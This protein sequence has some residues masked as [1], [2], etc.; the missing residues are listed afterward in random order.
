MPKG[1][2]SGVKRH[3]PTGPLGRGGTPLLGRT[4]ERRVGENAA[5][6]VLVVAH[7]WCW[8]E[9]VLRV[10]EHRDAAPVA[11]TGADVL[12]RIAADRV[13]VAVVDLDDA[14]GAATLAE[15]RERDLPCVAVSCGRGRNE[16]AAALNASASYA[17]K[18]VNYSWPD[19]LNLIP[20]DQSCQES[21]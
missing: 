10:L 17:V 21:N 5:L 16:V 4:V 2:P 1:P 11:A 13:D 12:R 14:D 20:S 9:A 18:S 3:L 6:R 8:R 19:F 7:G 15:L